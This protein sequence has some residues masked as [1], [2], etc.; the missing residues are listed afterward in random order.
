MFILVR[1]RID[2]LIY[3]SK[4]TNVVISP[5][6]ARRLKLDCCNKCYFVNKKTMRT[7][8][9]A[10]LLLL[11]TSRTSDGRVVLLMIDGFRWDYAERLTAKEVPAFSRLRDE[12]VRTRYVEPNFPSIS[13]PSWTTI[14]TG[15]ERNKTV[16]LRQ[17]SFAL[18][19]QAST[20]NLMALLVTTCT[21]SRLGKNSTWI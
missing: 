5:K 2:L 11:L 3:P 18:V 10:S 15:M 20:P 21:I 8:L 1:L 4:Q 16:P 12:G 9:V 14:A 13:M 6:Y 17:R 19:F 7:S